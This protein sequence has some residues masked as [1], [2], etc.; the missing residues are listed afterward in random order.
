MIEKSSSIRPTSHTTPIGEV[1]VKKYRRIEITAFQR[2]VLIVSG[3]AMVES[4]VAEVSMNASDSQETI[5]A[6]SEEGQAVLIE[7]VRLLEDTISKYA[8]FDSSHPPTHEEKK[9]L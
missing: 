5:E 6:W 7:A 9:T 8:Q 2:R 1:Y 3:D 4:G